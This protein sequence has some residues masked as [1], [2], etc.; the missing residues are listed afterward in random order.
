MGTFY[1][2]LSPS[3]NV[4][5]LRIGQNSKVKPYELWPNILKNIYIY[6]IKL[7]Y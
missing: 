1:D 3:Q 6:N 4:R 5:R 7:T 2:I